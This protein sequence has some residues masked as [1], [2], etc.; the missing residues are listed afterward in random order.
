[1]AASIEE[2]RKSVEAQIADLKTMIG[3]YQQQVDQHKAKDGSHWAKKRNE[4]QTELDE[5]KKKLAE[6]DLKAQEVEAKG[7][8]T[9]EVENTLEETD[10]AGAKQAVKV[11]RSNLTAQIAKLHK[12]YGELCF[13]EGSKTVVNEDYKFKDPS[14]LAHYKEALK[15]VTELTKDREDKRKLVNQQNRKRKAAEDATEAKKAAKVQYVAQVVSQHANGEPSGDDK[16]GTQLAEEPLEELSVQDLL[17]VV[18]TASRGN[19]DSQRELYHAERRSIKVMD[20]VPN[21]PENADILNAAAAKLEEKIALQK[22]WRHG[23]HGVLEMKFQLTPE[24]K[25]ALSDYGAA[26]L[27][28]AE[29]D[30]EQDCLQQEAEAAEKSRLEKKTRLEKKRDRDNEPGPSEPLKAAKVK[31]EP[32]KVKLEP[33][34]VKLEPAKVEVAK[35]EVAKPVVVTLDSESDSESKSSGA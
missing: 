6:I 9:P 10:Y 17:G 19:D 7:G 23:Y 5:E 29:L 26:V 28:Q 25:K 20:E 18:D 13:E 12:K 34:K 8:A 15:A 35:V 16:N 11:A 27:K 14:D 3:F 32:A 1:M 4:A 31:L 21:E 30:A 33:A 2:S 22:L 24:N